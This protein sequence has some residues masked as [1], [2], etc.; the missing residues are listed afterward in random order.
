MYI[1]RYNHGLWGL[2]MANSSSGR[3]LLAWDFGA[4]LG[5]LARLRPLAQALE[6]RGHTVFFAVRDL[7]RIDALPSSMRVLPAPTVSL[8]SVENKIRDAANFADILY[9]AGFADQRLLAAMVRG[10][11]SLFE[12]VRPD[13]VVQDYSPFSQVALQGLDIRSV[14]TGTG[15]VCPPDIAP[16]PGIRPWED[17]YPDRL[18]Q[19]EAQVLDI[20]NQQLERQGEQ[21]LLGVGELYRRSDINLLGTFA[22]LDHYP[23][24]VSVLDEKTSYCGIWSDLQGSAQE[25]PAARGPRVFAYLKPFRA[26]PRLLDHMQRS[27]FPVLAYV[28]GEFDVQRWDGG[29]IRIVKTP[30]DMAS[31]RHECDIAVLHAGHGST[32]NLLL[33]GKPILQLPAHVEQNLT[34]INTE[35]LGAGVAVSMGDADGIRAAF[36]RVATDPDMAAAARKFADKYSGFCQEQALNSAVTKIEQLMRDDSPR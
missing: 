8:A 7:S 14:N 9:N 11:R 22:E 15:F 23:Q 20:L 32:A 28:A 27:G 34:A 3:V 25:W 10:W 4:D 35:R 13:V 29:N 18:A 16:L 26:L 21:P 1:T 31:V 17:H 30:L 2:A 24:R 33:A 36:D 5:H 12:L 19:T 6:R